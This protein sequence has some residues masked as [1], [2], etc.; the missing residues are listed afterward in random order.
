MILLPWPR[1]S[2]HSLMSASLFPMVLA[3][4]LPPKFVRWLESSQHF[5]LKYLGRGEMMIFLHFPPALIRGMDVLKIFFRVGQSAITITWYRPSSPCLG[6]SFSPSSLL[7]KKMQLSESW[8][9]IVMPGLLLTR[10]S[11]CLLV[12][13]IFSAFSLQKGLARQFMF[14]PIELSALAS[15]QAW[16]LPTMR[17]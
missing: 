7:P 10:F 1:S 12:F 15:W 17:I 14:S 16:L 6:S 3:Y 2:N 5:E 4:C 13:S 9:M 11:I 8:Y